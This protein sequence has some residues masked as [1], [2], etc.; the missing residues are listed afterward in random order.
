[1]DLKKNSICLGLALMAASSSA[2]CAGK[3]NPPQ[4]SD[5]PNA[6]SN[7]ITDDGEEKTIRPVIPK[8]PDVREESERSSSGE[9]TE[10][11]EKITD[12]MDSSRETEPEA[13]RKEA[14]TE[15]ETEAQTESETETEVMKEAL[16]PVPD[17]AMGQVKGLENE[18]ENACFDVRLCGDDWLVID[19]EKTRE[20][21][22]QYAPGISRYYEEAYAS[23]SDGIVN[24]TAVGKDSENCAQDILDQYLTGCGAMNIGMEE[25]AYLAGKSVI[26]RS[27]QI[28]GAPT[29]TYL[30][31][32][33]GAALLIS[34]YYRNTEVFDAITS[35][36]SSMQEEAGWMEDTW[37]MG[38]YSIT[39]PEGF[40]I[41]PDNSSSVCANLLSR[42][43]DVYVLV[44]ED[45]DIQ[46][47]RESDAAGGDGHI[48]TSITED[49][50][51]TPMG[52]GV[53]LAMQMQSADLV[54]VQHE[55][56]VCA[57]EDVIKYILT[58]PEDSQ[59]DARMVL[60]S[61][62]RNTCFSPQETDTEDDS[63]F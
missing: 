29:Y 14:E 59:V 16:A 38:N 57:G 40:F 11:E 55:Y 48:V 2:G 46:E 58:L 3:K 28:N 41:D 52:D 12:G 13:E 61:M 42:Q 35:C 26:R 19:E 39:T 6:V 15:K 36:I 20:L 7:V 18:Y 34:I 21:Q 44:Y 60:D 22:D 43:A 49:V 47:E 5:P 4:T 62:V 51:S 45:A 63:D 30:F 37:Q 54:Y 50:I 23:S 1:M 24:I 9:E 33:E 8:A 32:T 31:E 17:Y 53:Y 25:T 56:L 27:A 10:E